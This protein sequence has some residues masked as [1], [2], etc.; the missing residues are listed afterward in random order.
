[1]KSES[2]EL[3]SWTTGLILTSKVLV[4]M[5]KMPT[6]RSVFAR[7]ENITIE[8]SKDRQN[9]ILYWMVESD[10]RKI[11]LTTLTR[12]THSIGHTESLIQSRK[13]KA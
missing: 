11:F 13:K 2:E 5:G 10:P 7:N 12:E 3:E 9:L 6:T 8:S 4:R 1:M